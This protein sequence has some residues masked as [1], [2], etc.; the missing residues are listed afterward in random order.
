MPWPKGRP[1]PPEMLAALVA[2]AKRARENLTPED[3]DRRSRRLSKIHR[4]SWAQKSPEERAKWAASGA[5]NLEKARSCIGSVQEAA[6]KASDASAAARKERKAAE[7]KIP[8]LDRLTKSQRADY[9][10]FR[11]KEFDHD[12]ALSLVETGMLPR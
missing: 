11:G 5:K 10:L 6:R 9:W 3:R 2:G 1:M 7:E 8:A 4:D 12:E